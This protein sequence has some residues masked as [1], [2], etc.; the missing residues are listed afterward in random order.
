MTPRKWATLLLFTTVAAGCGEEL[1]VH[2]HVGSFVTGPSASSV[3][4][5]TFVDRGRWTLFQLIDN[6]PTGDWPIP[7][8]VELLDSRDRVLMTKTIDDAVSRS[9]AS[10]K[11]HRKLTWRFDDLRDPFEANLDSDGNLPIDHVLKDGERYNLRFTL[12]KSHSHK[13]EVVVLSLRQ[14]YPWQ[15]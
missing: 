8:R 1:Q 12:P 6:S 14:V 2:E 9:E 11:G 4:D 7:F 15:H 5:V 10:A 3:T 13:Y